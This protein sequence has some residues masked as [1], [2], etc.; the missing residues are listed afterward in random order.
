MTTTAAVSR[1]S[2]PAAAVPDLGY[3]PVPDVFTLPQ[4]M[5]FGAC[6]GVALDSKGHIFVLNRGV[7]ALM[8]FDGEGNYIRTLAHDLFS[9]PHGLRV[10]AEDNIWPLTWARISW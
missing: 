7:H 3:V 8:E 1:S 9:R 10:D 2:L 4:G 6:S 5:N